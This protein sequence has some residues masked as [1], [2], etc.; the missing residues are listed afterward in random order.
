MDMLINP[1]MSSI[2]NIIGYGD[3]Q[4]N[5]YAILGRH[6][7]VRPEIFVQSIQLDPYKKSYLLDITFKKITKVIL[8]RA[9]YRS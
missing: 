3:Y 8:F 4:T 1:H 6:V 5:G 7:T 9:P 2:P